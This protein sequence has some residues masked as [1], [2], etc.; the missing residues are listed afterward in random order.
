MR[1]LNNTFDN[2]RV[3]IVAK[4]GRHLVQGNH[5]KCTEDPIWHCHYVHIGTSYEKHPVVYFKDNLVEDHWWNLKIEGHAELI[6][7]GGNVSR[8]GSRTGAWILG[9]SRSSF[10]GDAFLNNGGMGDW[11]GIF[12][13]D[14]A[15]VDLGGG[16]ILFD[17]VT[18]SSAGNNQLIGNRNSGDPTRDVW[19]TVSGVTVKAEHNHWGDDDPSDQVAGT[20]DYL[21]VGDDSPAGD[22][23]PP[24]QVWRTDTSSPE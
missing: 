6:S 19:N 11:A 14:A 20:V 2:N 18:S 1:L 24:D 15:K 9:D 7:L 8:R 4:D 17:G 10:S 12:I 21:P 22:L 23:P 13:E 16:S 5:V 3:P